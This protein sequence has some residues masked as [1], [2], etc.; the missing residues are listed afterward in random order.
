MSLLHFTSMVKRLH[1]L[2]TAEWVQ[3]RLRE[4]REQRARPEIAHKLAVIRAA[5]RFQAPAPDIEQ[6]NA[7]IERGYLEDRSSS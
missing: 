5:T 7:E 4:A 2:T 3:E 1:T 6:M